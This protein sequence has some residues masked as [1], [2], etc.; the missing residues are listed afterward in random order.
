[1]SPASALASDLLD[2][3]YRVELVTDNRGEKFSSMFENMKIHVVKSGT[4]TAGIIGKVKGAINLGF[5]FVH[6]LGLVKSLKPDIVVG[7]GGYPSVP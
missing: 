1:M 2:R 5:G 6:A 7:F 4:A 3:G